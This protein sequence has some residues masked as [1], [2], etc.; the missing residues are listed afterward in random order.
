[1]NKAVYSYLIYCGFSPVHKGFRLILG[2]VERL[3]SG[4]TACRSLKESVFSPLAEAFGM[5]LGG[6]QKNIK[7]A[8]DYACLNSRIEVFSEE[9]AVIASS[10]GGVSCGTF[11]CY[12][13]D[14]IR[15]AS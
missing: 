14:K 1:M 9:F 4:N 12:V 6:V 7:N 11:L 15:F 13:A 2:A 10:G 8:I 3:L 5:S